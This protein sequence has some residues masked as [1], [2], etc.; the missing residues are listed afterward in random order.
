M[1]RRNNGSIGRGAE[2]PCQTHDALAQRP[3]RE[4]SGNDAQ[5][6]RR[7]AGRDGL[8][9]D[10]LAARRA[11]DRADNCP[12]A[13]VGGSVAVAATASQADGNSGGRQ[14]HNG[15]GR[16]HRWSGRLRAQDAGHG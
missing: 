4:Q 16:Q 5:R 13:R 10:L 3:G 15:V 14:C 7:L 1:L 2:Y 8:G 12:C 6:V 11:N 9:A